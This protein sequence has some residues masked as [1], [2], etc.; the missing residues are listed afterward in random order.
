MV[1][2]DQWET[3]MGF[4][5]L[6]KSKVSLCLEKGPLSGLGRL[7]GF[8]KVKVDLAP[9]GK[10]CLAQRWSQVLFL[11]PPASTSVSTPQILPAL[12]EVSRDFGWYVSGS[13]S[14]EHTHMAC[15]PV[16]MCPWRGGLYA[17]DSPEPI[18]PQ[19]HGRHVVGPTVDDG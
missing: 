14:S 2:V 12:P 6:T 3:L 4:R 13:E 8:G 15:A 11:P 5:V 10:P 7:P 18:T 19:A 1:G 17:A 16:S 9:G